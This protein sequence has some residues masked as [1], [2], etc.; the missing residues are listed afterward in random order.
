MEINVSGCF[1][2]VITHLVLT[3]TFKSIICSLACGGDKNHE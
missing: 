3:A 2:S 1:T